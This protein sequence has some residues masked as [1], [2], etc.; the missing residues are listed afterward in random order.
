MIDSIN[1]T[2][3][4]ALGAGTVPGNGRLG[5]DWYAAKAPLLQYFPQTKRVLDFKTAGIA[6][7]I[8]SAALPTDAEWPRLRARIAADA[9]EKAAADLDQVLNRPI[10]AGTAAKFRAAKSGAGKATLCETILTPSWLAPRLQA[11]I[12][13]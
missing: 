8:F 2:D 12:S 4:I 11:C 10:A 1:G 7:W 6:D 5:L 13:W 3:A 9:G